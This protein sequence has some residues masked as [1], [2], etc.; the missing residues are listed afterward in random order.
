MKHSTLSTQRKGKKEKRE[1]AAQWGQGQLLL[2]R[3]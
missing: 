2:I 1:K 3:D